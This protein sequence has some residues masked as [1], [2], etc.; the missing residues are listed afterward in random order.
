MSATL[1]I[2]CFSAGLTLGLLG[3]GGAVLLVPLFVYLGNFTAHEAIPLSLLIVSLTSFIASLRYFKRKNVH[4]RLFFIFSLFGSLG[5]TAGSQ[6][7]SF[8]SDALLLFLFGLL[9]IFTG[10][11]LIF[12]NRPETQQEEI[13]CHPRFIPSM[14]LSVSVGFLTGLLGVGGGFMIVPALALIMKCSMRTA[15]GTSLAVLAVNSAAGFSGHFQ[16][17]QVS[18]ANA[19]AYTAV[20][21][22]GAWLGSGFSHRV[23]SVFLQHSFGILIMSVGFF[24]VV[25]NGFLFLNGGLS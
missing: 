12:K 3:G 9:M 4:W 1:L 2:L 13:T 15:I 20:T 14:L 6:A 16:H 23:S 19:L 25:K 21:A 18:L 24:L 11:L 10:F 5:A 17:F 22:S 8:F 7:A